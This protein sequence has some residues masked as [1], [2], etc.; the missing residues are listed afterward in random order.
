REQPEMRRLLQE[1]HRGN[2]RRPS[3]AASADLMA[4]VAFYEHHVGQNQRSKVL[5]SQVRVFRHNREHYQKITANLLPIL[6]MLTSGDLGRSLSPDAFDANDERPI[7]NLEKCVRGGHVLYLSL[8]SLPDP[9]VASAI[10]AIFLADLAA[11][12]GI[13]YNLG[14]DRRISLFVDEISNVIN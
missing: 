4:F 8:D 1:A 5:D 12:A 6:S 11:L 3:E 9:A 10:G 13:R 7:I 2:M 14:G